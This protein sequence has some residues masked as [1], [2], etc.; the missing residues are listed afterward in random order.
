MGVDILSAAG[1]PARFNE[2]PD[3]VSYACFRSA[4]L[5]A[6]SHAMRQTSRKLRS[7]SQ[8]AREHACALDRLA[9]ALADEADQLLADLDWRAMAGRERNLYV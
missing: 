3:N 2:R 9:G 7:R 8:A 1:A 5:Y 4:R 6:W